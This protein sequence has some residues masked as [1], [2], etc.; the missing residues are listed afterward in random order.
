MITINQNDNTVGVLLSGGAASALL[1]Y[2]VAKEAKMF[3]KKIIAVTL[4]F[5]DLES[6]EV[7]SKNVID[8]V[9]SNLDIDI[10]HVVEFVDQS[11]TYIDEYETAYFKDVTGQLKYDNSIDTYYDGTHKIDQTMP[12]IVHAKTDFL[13]KNTVKDA[14]GTNFSFKDL[15]GTD[16]AVL[17]KDNGLL[18]TLYPIT[19]SCESN[20]DKTKEFKVPCGAC[21]EC[22]ERF[23]AVSQT[24]GV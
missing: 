1:L 21:W 12:E 18:D 24:I 23:W 13:P 5:H 14:L 3:N 6:S 17:Y 4:V 15:T 16:I 22:K 20:S 11:R 19:W 9:K 2:L 8:F 10:E 7:Y